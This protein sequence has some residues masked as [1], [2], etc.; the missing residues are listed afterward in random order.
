MIWMA[1]YVQTVNNFEEERVVKIFTAHKLAEMIEK[2]EE[3]EKVR[4]FK[5]KGHLDKAALAK[6][7]RFAALARK[8]KGFQFK[9]I[10]LDLA[11]VTQIDFSFVA[12]LLKA[13]KDCTREYHKLALINLKEQPQHMLWMAKVGH[14]FPSYSTRDEAV[15]DLET[16]F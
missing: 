5:I 15:R 10:L 3:R 2:V 11:E 6:L 7:E 16:R 4:I 14:L 8:Q 12:A 1:S 9:H 13:L